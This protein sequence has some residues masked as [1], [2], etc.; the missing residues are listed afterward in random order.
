MSRNW[1]IALAAS[2]LLASPHVYAE[3]SEAEIQ[4]L[5]E[6]LA[7][8][9]QRLDVLE[10]ENAELRSARTRDAEAIAHSSVLQNSWE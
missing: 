2:G 4:E 3:V 7:A 10:A 1:L 6:Q 9:A 5:R 8:L